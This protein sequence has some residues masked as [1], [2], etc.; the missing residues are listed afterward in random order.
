MNHLVNHR[1]SKKQPMRWSPEGAHLLLQVRADVLNGTQTDR[2]RQVHTQFRGPL[3]YLPARSWP[4]T[5]HFS[6]TPE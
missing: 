3:T 2:Y 5:P 4:A 1:M 6:A